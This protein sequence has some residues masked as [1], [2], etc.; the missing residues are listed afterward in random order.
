[1]A[2]GTGPLEALRRSWDLSRG[3][4]VRTLGYLLL[5]GIILGITGGLV[6]AFA[7]FATGS[8]TTAADQSRMFGFN[9]AVSKLMSIIAAP[10][11]VSAIVLYYFDLRMRKEEYSFGT[12]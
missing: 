6:A 7:D 8:L 3:Y 2:E 10:F 12:V 9:F 1:M 5:I 11:Y 4:V